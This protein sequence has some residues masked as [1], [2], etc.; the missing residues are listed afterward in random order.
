[1]LGTNGAGKSTL[2]KTIV[3]LLRPTTGQIT[4]GEDDVTREPPE[5]MASRGVVLVPEGRQLFGEMTVRENLILGAYSRRN[6][7]QTRE[8]DLEGVV[9]LFPVLGERSAAAPPT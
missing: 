5:A 1:M 4:F 3:G 6:R 9:D 8:Q 2:L 7:R